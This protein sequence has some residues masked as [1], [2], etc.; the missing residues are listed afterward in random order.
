MITNTR[1]KHGFYALLITS[2]CTIQQYDCLS[3]SHALMSVI[4]GYSA[5]VSRHRHK[6]QQETFCQQ[7][8]TSLT[9]SGQAA[10]EES[11]LKCRHA[12]NGEIDDL[13][14]LNNL[15]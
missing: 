10:P 7:M 15:T 13:H 4:F 6:L 2:K 5:A 3:F 12:G 9:D 1:E 11:E 14:L 8:C